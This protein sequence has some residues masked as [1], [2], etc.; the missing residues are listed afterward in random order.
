[1]AELFAVPSLR[2]FVPACVAAVP[3]LAAS[4]SNAQIGPIT[5]AGDAGPGYGQQNAEPVNPAALSCDALKAKLQTAGQLIILSGP[6][7]AWGD[8]FYGPAVPRCQFWQIPVFTYVKAADGLCGVGYICVD[9]P[10]MD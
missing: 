2:H 5:G 8:T 4:L 7:G 3:F 9:K 1:M 10:S 6:K